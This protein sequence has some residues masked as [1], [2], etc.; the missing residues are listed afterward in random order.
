ASRRPGLPKSAEVRSVL[1]DK[2]RCPAV[3]PV[4]PCFSEENFHV[5]VKRQR[6]R[7]SVFRCAPFQPKF[8]ALK[9]HLRPLELEKLSASASDMECEDEEQPHP[10]GKRIP[11]SAVTVPGEKTLS[12]VIDRQHG[13]KRRRPNKRWRPPRGEMVSTP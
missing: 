2:Y 1:F 7:R 13:E 10:F 6:S 5:S 9:I 11:Q 8:T 3:R 4:F 12:D